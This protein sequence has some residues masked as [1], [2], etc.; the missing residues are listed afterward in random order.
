MEATYS[1]IISGANVPVL[2]SNADGLS[3]INSLVLLIPGHVNVIKDGEDNLDIKNVG[4]INLALT[5]QTLKQRSSIKI[6][7]ED[8]DT[9]EY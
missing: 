2:R 1:I 4:D 7:R 3:L 6:L 8:V 9:N 5:E